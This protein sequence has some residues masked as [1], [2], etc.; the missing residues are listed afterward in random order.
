MSLRLQVVHGLATSI[1]YTVKSF[2]QATSM[3]VLGV[4]MDSTLLGCGCSSSKLYAAG[5]AP[6]VCCCAAATCAAVAA[7]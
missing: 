4:W 2:S 7:A 1:S 6:A 5:C 3:H